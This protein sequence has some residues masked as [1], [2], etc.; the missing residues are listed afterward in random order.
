MKRIRKI[1][2][3]L[4]TAV[5][6]VMMYELVFPIRALALTGG[7]SQ[8]EVES[9]EPVGTTEMVDVFS[10][11]FVYNI[12]LLD[13]G[14]YPINISYHGGIGMEQEAS[15]VGLGWN[16]NPGVVNRSLRGLPDDFA[17]DNVHKEFNIK[18]NI[19]VGLNLSNILK[20]K[21]EYYGTSRKI[22]LDYDLNAG[23]YFNNYKGI[24]YNFGGGIKGSKE[25][26][27]GIFASLGANY[28]SQNLGMDISPNVGIASLMSLG[29]TYNGA[30]G[31]EQFGIRQQVSGRYK[32]NIKNKS[33]KQTASWSN[34]GSLISYH[35]PS[36]VPVA[37][38]NMYSASFNVS[39]TPGIAGL[40]KFN[41]LPLD[42]TFSEHG[43]R[44]DYR[45][46]NYPAYGYM[47]SAAGYDSDE[48]LMDF[49]REKDNHPN[50]TLTYLGIPQMTHDIYSVSGQGTG[51][52][53]RPHLSSAG[54]VKDPDFSSFSLPSG[55]AGIELGLG[56]TITG[57][58]HLGLDLGFT[59][60]RQKTNV[61][62]ASNELESNIRYHAKNG[63][64]GYE[65]WY[66]KN[67]GEKT[68]T[69]Q[70]YVY[71]KLHGDK[72]LNAKIKNFF[73]IDGKLVA[74]GSENSVSA[75][76]K[77]EKRELRNSHVYSLLAGDNEW[78]LQKNLEYSKYVMQGERLI[79][80]TLNMPR[81]GN[82]RNVSH[83]SEISNYNADGSRYVY[84]IPAYNHLQ[85]EASFA[86]H[87]IYTLSKRSKTRIC[88]A[89]G[90][91][92]YSHADASLANQ[93][94]TDHFYQSQ[95]LPPYAHSYLLTAVLSP[96]YRDRTGDGPTSDDYG[97]YTRLNYNMATESYKWRVPY[98]RNKSK[99]GGNIPGGMGA[100]MEGYMSDYTDDKV[101]YAYG[102]KEIWYLHSVE[103]KTHVALFFI[104]E[105]EDGLEA[106]GESGGQGTQKLSKLDKIVLL[107]REEYIRNSSNLL[108]A[109]PVKTVHFQYDYSLCPG[110]PNH[111][112]YGQGKLTLKKLWFTYGN[113]VKGALNTY[114]FDYDEAA[115]FSYN[116]NATDGWGN[117][118][119]EKC[120]YLNNKDYPYVMQEKG[121]A[122][123]Y[124]SAWSLSEIKLPSGGKIKVRYEADD[125]AY[126][127]D[128]Q[129]MQM[130][131]VLGF[132]EN[133]N[134]SEASSALYKG[135]R[136]RTKR[137]LF[138]KVDQDVNS[139]TVR[140]YFPNAGEPLYFKFRVD[141]DKKGS[142]EYVSGYFR[143][144]VP[145][146]ESSHIGIT[147]SGGK[148]IGWIYVE[149][150]EIRG[151]DIH[152]A[153]HAAFQLMKLELPHL[154]FPETDS[155]RSMN[156]DMG[157][158]TGLFGFFPRAVSLIQGLDLYLL[159][160][161]MAQNAAVDG[162]SNLRLFV[163]SKAKLGGGC[164][165]KQ[166]L[167][168]DEWNALSGTEET[169]TTG[170]SYEYTMEEHG[171]TISSGVAT[172]EPPAIMDECPLKKPNKTYYE[173]LPLIM[174]TNNIFYYEEPLGEMYYPGAS[175][176]YRK[177][178]T[179]NLTPEEVY[180]EG[181]Y[182]FGRHGIGYSVHEFYTA[183]E[184]PIRAQ[185]TETEIKKAPSLAM[186]I[187]KLAGADF[188]YKAMSQ[189]FLIQLNDMHGK[190]KSQAEY[191][192]VKPDKPISKTTYYYKV[193]DQ[194]APQK[195][196]DNEVT[197]LYK[198]GT[199]N[200]LQTGG[201]DGEK[202]VIGKNTEVVFDNRENEAYSLSAGL[203]VNA[204]FTPL[205]VPIPS[206]YP[207]FYGIRHHQLRTSSTAKIVT[208][209]GLVDRIVVENESASLET[210][211]LAF[212]AVTGE[213]LLTR[214]QTEYKD[215]EYNLS[216]P[217]YWAYEGMG[218][219]SGSQ[220]FSFELSGGSAVNAE[221]EAAVPAEVY[222]ALSEGDELKKL[223]GPGGDNLKRAWVLSKRVNYAEQS[224]CTHDP[225]SRHIVLI[226]EKGAA[227]P[228][229]S[230]AFEVIN[231]GRKN[232]QLLSMASVVSKGD[233]LDYTNNA[234][235]RK[236]DFDG[237]DVISASAVEYGDTWPVYDNRAVMVRPATYT[238]GAVRFM[239]QVLLKRVINAGKMWTGFQDLTPYLNTH[240]WQGG[241]SYQEFLY[242]RS[243]FG[244]V[245]KIVWCPG[246]DGLGNL[247]IRLYRP[248]DDY[249]PSL[250]DN[251]AS[252]SY[253]S[254][255]Y[256]DFILT[257]TGSCDAED[258]LSGP[259]G[260][261]QAS[262]PDWERT[263][264]GMMSPEFYLYTSSSW[265][266]N[267]DCRFKVSTTCYTTSDYCDY[268]SEDFSLSS[269]AGSKVNP[270]LINHKGNWRVKNSYQYY[271][272]RN[273]G[274]YSRTALSSSGG[275]N[276]NAMNDL[277]YLQD[278]IP[279]WKAQ[280]TYKGRLSS[281][282]ENN[283][284]GYNPWVKSSEL[285]LASPYG[286]ELESR[287]ALNIYSA[288]LFGYNHTLPVA[289]AQNAQQREIFADNFEEAY[290]AEA[291]SEKY[292]LKWLMH[293][294][295]PYNS[296]KYPQ[297]SGDRAHSGEYAAL[298]PAGGRLSAIGE[299]E[300][301]WTDTVHNP[302][303]QS[304]EYVL[305]P[306][307][308]IPVFGP[309][310]G[311]KYMISYWVYDPNGNHSLV[312]KKTQ[313]L[314]VYKNML[315]FF[316]MYNA[317]PNLCS[318][319]NTNSMSYYYQNYYG[320]YSSSI[321]TTADITQPVMTLR[322]EI[323]GWKL[324][325]GEIVLPAGTQAMRI[326]L[327]NGGGNA[328]YVDDFRIFPADASMKS[329]VYGRNSRR[330]M[331]TLDENNYASFYEYDEEGNVIRM[332]RETE[333]GIM[334]IKENRENL[335]R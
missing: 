84:G 251:C 115:N 197:V 275:Y 5:L 7:P 76:L 2:R 273:T 47:H 79:E 110:V 267:W 220:F 296:E 236:S 256:C 196:L 12:P 227:I 269:V 212:D 92:D 211:H 216:Y 241:D 67:E 323:N 107:T 159:E 128:Q 295:F 32:K 238:T 142:Y 325:E 30:N 294:P 249:C 191:S 23:I 307:H 217:A 260:L 155:Y 116:M 120:G 53:F 123:L 121:K 9:F 118:K 14:G 264:S 91:Y 177:V 133:T 25:E 149:Q 292:H 288:A 322:S 321:W 314:S 193:K 88:Q 167:F 306:E 230:Y 44:E 184:F 35:N 111:S 243:K 54:S 43:V 40:G 201:G 327:H 313:S 10:G 49:N 1:S 245:S 71:G 302:V 50:K 96:D 297:I 153:V 172:I 247:R 21:S 262:N 206:F 277:G 204:E 232:M 124:A 173:K 278:F 303:V 34:G 324:L 28:N 304:T 61:W 283:P 316:R 85:K 66:F 224:P 161:N 250:P 187:L 70:G 125:Y 6:L 274:E 147:T 18:P 8:P 234:F 37:N 129:A 80:W 143:A 207:M 144:A 228:S 141:L 139:T 38:P 154:I 318:E 57:I 75:P 165:V 101:T 255:G 182:P 102:E 235:G 59:L 87:D 258:V 29:L 270:Y 200:D 112:S 263:V 169:F 158:V 4:A 170:L 11:D 213:V 183:Y 176:G 199:M 51:G 174:K 335:N 290:V 93:K 286:E 319:T 266:G 181:E 106:A 244:D 109:I 60:S 254:H 136:K 41:G 253:S 330:L 48:G 113:N 300:M 246:N 97:N 190:L 281:L 221:G 62:R 252:C 131:Q 130:T 248:A 231:S 15:W 64:N 261:N 271:D 157:M 20:G 229:G 293:V 138:F 285:T 89:E 42:A 65:T 145:G 233:P 46:R 334:T 219:K 257:T 326:N 208:T 171:K 240:L 151:I 298:I 126:V 127:Q 98:T 58:S 74:G 179:R 317:N 209:Y 329:F 114:E 90:L 226:D 83:I 132:G 203:E 140:D 178:S 168:S 223:Y 214:T 180:P 320:D 3:P 166:I 156:P 215:H 68:E 186:G 202:A 36:Y 24:G 146:G 311:K 195:E 108:A 194:N 331:A 82:G 31:V 279:F 16:I 175:V 105:R 222:E 310:T 134:F 52:S 289:V 19:T 315:D 72:L 33:K 301:A 239:P 265:D 135:V 291:G 39:F 104:S 333:K 332:K 160:N 192:L 17:G 205:M 259:V 119:P 210:Q 137:F 150:E 117:Y 81:S 189:G 268:G 86:V 225:A 95:S 103:T 218:P 148:K 78:C 45:S 299:S 26:N 99:S 185:K 55:N 122:D 282:T 237:K 13:V 163:P 152:P 162:S 22:K 77:R 100:F 94:G 27:K 309:F 312:L 305:K 69:D 308:F 328:V 242:L 188:D 287:N 63:Y 284:Y 280:C 56:P 73:T 276:E 164:R 272:R 198:D